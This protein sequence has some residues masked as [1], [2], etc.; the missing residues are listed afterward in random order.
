MRAP[1]FSGK[2]SL[3][4]IPRR[5][6][7]RNSAKPLI[8]YLLINLGKNFFKELVVMPVPLTCLTRQTFQGVPWQGNRWVATHL[9]FRTPT[10]VEFSH[11]CSKLNNN[12]PLSRFVFLCFSSANSNP[13][14]NSRWQTACYRTTDAPHSREDINK[15]KFSN[16]LNG[17]LKIKKI[18]DLSWKNLS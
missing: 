5:K 17:K 9:N 11:R 10:G 2:C 14:L 6:N 4:E 1:H 12:N 8:L 16:D 15:F 7:S 3:P 13:S 18:K